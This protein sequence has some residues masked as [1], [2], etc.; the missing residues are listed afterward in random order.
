MVRHGAPVNASVFARPSSPARSGKPGILPSAS[1]RDVAASKWWTVSTEKRGTRIPVNVNADLKRVR[2]RNTGIRINASVLHASLHPVPSASHGTPTR[3]L[4]AVAVAVAV[5]VVVMV[6]VSLSLVVPSRDGT[7]SPV[8]VRA[9]FLLL[10]LQ[11]QQPRPLRVL[12]NLHHITILAITQFTSAL[13][14]FLS[15]HQHQHL[16]IIIYSGIWFLTQDHDVNTLQSVCIAASKQV[17]VYVNAST[18]RVFNNITN[19]EKRRR[20]RPL[21]TCIA[22]FQESPCLSVKECSYCADRKSVV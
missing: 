19:Q 8:G 13:L 20:R 10:Q 21:S 14:F 7:Q 2:H 18:P 9:S 5:L 12:H 16:H 17:C 1:A 4:V 3:A 11:L 22:S 15:H 6:D